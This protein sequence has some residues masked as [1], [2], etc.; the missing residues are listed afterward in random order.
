[1]PIVQYGEDVSIDYDS[2]SAAPYVAASRYHRVDDSFDIVELT[3]A[4][5]S[6]PATG[7]IRGNTSPPSHLATTI[8]TADG[9]TAGSTIIH[10]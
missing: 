2:D 1:M 9:G 10:K 7:G 5:P 6:V 3:P 8:T 4:P